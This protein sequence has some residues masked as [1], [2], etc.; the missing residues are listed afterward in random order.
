MLIG[1]FIDV[2][3]RGKAVANPALWKNIGGTTSVLAGLVSGVLAIA[4]AFGYRFDLPDDFAQSLAGGIAA[5]L[6]V[7][8]GSLHWTTSDKVGLPSKRDGDGDANAD[9]YA[10]SVGVDQDAVRKFLTER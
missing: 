9:P 5:V 6:F 8:S 10:N 7:F 1:D 2:W 4:S 3:K